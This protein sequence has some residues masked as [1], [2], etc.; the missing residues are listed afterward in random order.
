MIIITPAAS[1]PSSKKSKLGGGSTPVTISATANSGDCCG[2]SI[3][4]DRVLPDN[5][6]YLSPNR[7]ITSS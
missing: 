2:K 6:E 1:Q 3:L 4:S 5:N 7:K